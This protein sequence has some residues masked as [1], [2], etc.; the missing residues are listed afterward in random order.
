MGSSI[1]IPTIF[2]KFSRYEVPPFRPCIRW[3][4][5]SFC[6]LRTVRAIESSRLKILIEEFAIYERLSVVINRAATAPRSIRNPT[7][8]SRL[9]P[10]RFGQRAHAPAFGISVSSC[11]SKG[12]F[13]RSRWI[14]RSIH[15][16]SSGTMVASAF[17]SF[18]MAAFRYCGKHSCKA[19]HGTGLAKRARQHNEV[20]P[21]K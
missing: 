12:A 4:R 15:A 14:S 16:R 17:L 11:G 5:G 3:F 9:L 1:A 10:V 21:K 7:E 2:S 20:V 18:R 19:R 6:G 8:I 13:V